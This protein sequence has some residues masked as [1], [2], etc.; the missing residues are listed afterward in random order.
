MGS[1]DPIHIGHI[2][3]IRAALNFVDKVIVVPSGH[4]PWKKNEP[5]PFALRVEMIRKSILPF[6]DAVDVSDIEGYFEPPYYANKPLNHFKKEYK[7]DELYIICGSD[8]VDKI[9]LWKNA[10]NDI[11]PFYKVLS[12]D[13]ES[14][15]NTI[16]EGIIEEKTAVYGDGKQY[17]Y[18]N[19]SINPITVSSTDIRQLIKDNKPTYPLLPTSVYEIINN[20]KLYV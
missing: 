19:L 6:D 8:T 4:N 17:E 13:R 20:Y 11:L 18:I 9:P 15:G 3:M 14:N 16:K 7:Y 2:N 12:L 10:E 1:F 5:A